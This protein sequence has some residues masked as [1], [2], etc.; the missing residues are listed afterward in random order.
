MGLPVPVNFLP[1]PTREIAYP[2]RPVPAGPGRPASLY[3]THNTIENNYRPYHVKIIITNIVNMKNCFAS[4][5]Y[6]QTKS[7][8]NHLNFNELKSLTSAGYC[9]EQPDD[10]KIK[11]KTYSK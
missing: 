2:T 3:Y 7:L 6:N 4:V 1:D 9:C 8:L 5:P 11:P 10:T